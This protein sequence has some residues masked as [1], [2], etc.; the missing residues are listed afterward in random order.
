MQQTG[1]NE[2]DL[3]S[4]LR[5]G[6]PKAYAVIINSGVNPQRLSNDSSAELPWL[7]PITGV[8]EQK[9]YLDLIPEAGRQ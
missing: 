5:T 8:F 3:L 4:Y 2:T 9:N 1:I 7:T 6:D